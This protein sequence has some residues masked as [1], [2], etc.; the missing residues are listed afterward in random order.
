MT[1]AD[2]VLYLL[3]L[4]L[5]PLVFWFFW[6][7]VSQALQADIYLNGQYQQRVS[8]AHDRV[9]QIHGDQG[10][11]VL[12]I[13]DGKIRFTDSPCTLKRC[14]HSGWLSHSGEFAACVPN[15]VSVALLGTT[16]ASRHYDTINF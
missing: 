7:P 13:K 15:K 1:L 6:Q 4:L 12:Q 11:S 8:L 16:S 14:V 3:S 10:D 9:L 2:R 5:L